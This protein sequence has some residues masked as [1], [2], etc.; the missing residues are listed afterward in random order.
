MSSPVKDQ[1]HYWF[2]RTALLWRSVFVTSCFLLPRKHNLFCDETSIECREKDKVK[3]YIT[4]AK[5]D[6]S[7]SLKPFSK[8]SFKHVLFP[9]P[10]MFRVQDASIVLA[11]VVGSR[12]LRNFSKHSFQHN[13]SECIWCINS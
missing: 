5:V 7:H 1:T 4:R 11:K 9:L 12:P 3:G 8:H 6:V 10:Q 2:L 13:K